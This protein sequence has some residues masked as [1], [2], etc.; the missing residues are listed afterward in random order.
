VAKRTLPL[1]VRNRVSSKKASPKKHLVVKQK[2]AVPK[3]LPAVKVVSQSLLDGVTVGGVVDWRA[4]T[5]GPV[6][7]VQ[8]VVDGTVTST[9][10][11]EPWSASWDTTLLSAGP[12]ALAVRALAKDGRVAASASVG[13]MVA[14]PQPAEPPITPAP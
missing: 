14:Q 6:A 5:I 9:A 12:H 11:R 7:R 1:V 3:P 10:N 2:P 8:F 13:V 4:H